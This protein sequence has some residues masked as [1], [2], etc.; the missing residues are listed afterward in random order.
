VA[1]TAGRAESGVHVPAAAALETAT[2]P[3]AS[4]DAAIAAHAPIAFSLRFTVRGLIVRGFTVWD[5]S[6][7]Y[8]CPSIVNYERWQ[9]I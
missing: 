8:N 6:Q 2:D 1:A 9:P 5:I 4:N 7:R 3:T